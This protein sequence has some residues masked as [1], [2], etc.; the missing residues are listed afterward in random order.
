MRKEPFSVEGSWSLVG[1]LR[2]YGSLDVFSLLTFF[3]AGEK[4]CPS[5]LEPSHAF[6]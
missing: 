4:R 3:S 6:S 5:R 1:F 2:T